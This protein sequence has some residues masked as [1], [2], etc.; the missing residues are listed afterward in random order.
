MENLLCFVYGFCRADEFFYRSRRER[1]KIISIFCSTPRDSCGILVEQSW[2]FNDYWLAESKL[3]NFY[4]KGEHHAYSGQRKCWRCWHRTLIF[5]SKDLLKKQLHA[6]IF[7]AVLRSSPSVLLN[8]PSGCKPGNLG[9]G[10]YRLTSSLA[11][12]NSPSKHVLFCFVASATE[13]GS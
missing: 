5:W 6:D 9:N 7:K 4:I 11:N 3:V 1:R 10:Y 13:I 2:I 8:C 12:F